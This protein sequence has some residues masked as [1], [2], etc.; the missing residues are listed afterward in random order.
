M[1]WNSL[2]SDHQGDIIFLLEEQT[3]MDV[4]LWKKILKLKLKV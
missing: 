1:L 2:A 4:F 3:K